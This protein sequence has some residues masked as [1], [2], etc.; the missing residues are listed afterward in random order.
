MLKKFAHLPEIQPLNFNRNNL[1]SVLLNVE[2]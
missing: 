1:L 2:E